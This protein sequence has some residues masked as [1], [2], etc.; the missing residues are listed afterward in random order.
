MIAYLTLGVDDMARAKRFYQSFMQALGYKLKVSSEG[1][2]YSMPPMA[3][4]SIA[5]PDLYVKQAFDGRPATAGNGTMVA[6][7][8]RSQQQVRDLHAAALL[9]GGLTKAHPVFGTPT[10]PIFMLAICVTRRAIKLR[11]SRT[12]EVSRGG[13][14]NV[15]P[16]F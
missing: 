4:Q 16:S 13:T 11:Y 8:A 3:G 6:F 12:T 15:A 9:A 7:Q 5:P 1:L 14:D 2:E 10:V